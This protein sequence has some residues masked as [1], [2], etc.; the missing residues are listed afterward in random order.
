MLPFVQGTDTVI[1][2]FVTVTTADILMTDG[3]S[4]ERR[5]VIPDDLQLPS[6]HDLSARI[7][8]VL[9]YAITKAGGQIDGAAAAKLFPPD[10][11][12]R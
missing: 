5:G 8:P 6:A 10:N 3:I 2:Y 11:N 4:L 12:I 9:A 1:T 7:D